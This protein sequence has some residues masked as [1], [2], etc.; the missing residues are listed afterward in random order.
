MP[1]AAH[2]PLHNP[3]QR[4]KQPV[5]QGEDRRREAQPAMRE[6]GHRR[7]RQAS[8]VADLLEQNRTDERCRTL[9]PPTSSR[10]SISGM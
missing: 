8:N 2:A 7:L 3:F 9:V 6:V 4:A 10:P 1:L 5:E